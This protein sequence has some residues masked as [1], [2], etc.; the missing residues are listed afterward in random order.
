MKILGFIYIL[1]D[2]MFPANY[3]ALMVM[4]NIMSNSDTQYI[5]P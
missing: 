2:Y 4:E 1:R 3:R 5:H